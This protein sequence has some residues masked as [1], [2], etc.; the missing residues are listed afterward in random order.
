M[1]SADKSTYAF[2]WDEPVFDSPFEQRSAAFRQYLFLALV[3]CGGKLEVRGPEA[4]EISITILT[5]TE[6]S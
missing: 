3:R 4:R 6:I 2:T 1:K 5:S